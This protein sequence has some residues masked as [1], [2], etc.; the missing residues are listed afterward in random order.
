[1][2]I[3]AQ[4]AKQIRDPMNVRITMSWVA[5]ESTASCSN[6]AADSKITDNTLDQQYSNYPMRSLADLQGDGFRLDGSCVLYDSSVSPS[7]ENGKIGARGTVDQTFSIDVSLTRP[8]KGVSMYITG[9]ETATINGTTY[10]LYEGWTPFGNVNTGSFSLTLTPMAGRR[11]EVGGATA[12]VFLTA[13]NRDI[14][15]AV[16][17]L[18]SDLSLYNQ[19]LPASELNADI[20]YDIDISSVL[21]I[22]PE[23]T[24]V[25]YQAGYTDEM[26]EPRKFY[27]EGQATWDNNLL[28]ITAVDSVHMLER[29]LTAF[30]LGSFSAVSPQSIFYTTAGFIKSCGVDVSYDNITGSFYSQTDKKNRI[31]SPD[32]LTCREFVSAVNNYITINN[33]PSFVCSDA[34]R[35]EYVINYVDAGW[36]T[37]R[38]TRNRPGY[39]IYEEDCGSVDEGVERY[40]TSINATTIDMAF[41][42]TNYSPILYGTEVGEATWFKDGGIAIDLNENV[43]NFA[44]GIPGADI[45]RAQY[46]VPIGPVDDRGSSYTGL[47]KQKEAYEHSFGGYLVGLANKSNTAGELLVEISAGVYTTIYPSFIDWNN[48][49]A[50]GEYGVVWSTQSAAW[51]ALVSGGYIESDAGEFALKVYGYKMAQENVVKTYY[52]GDPDLTGIPVDIDLPLFGSM[53]FVNSNGD[54]VS[55]LYPKTAVESVFNKSVKTGSFRWKGDPRMQPRDVV[56]FVRLDG[57]LEVITLENITIT[58]E[59]GGTVADITYRKGVV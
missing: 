28:S 21:A 2:S 6:Y 43:Y 9:A 49:F 51:S 54:F 46:F 36:P 13:D 37:L 39:I 29:K 32:G 55:E 4:N 48:G 33:I 20:Y 24:L 3:D 41:G 52:N 42:T 47:F 15:K 7:I 8:D 19:T 44:V 50:A 34:S 40:I 25:T 11:I 38:S 22:V 31:V 5:P 53:D 45:G 35:T 18:R 17:S 57:S 59:A 23:E 30:S 58:H 56:T 10:T 16:L 26:T 1:M 12:G 14:V 27:L